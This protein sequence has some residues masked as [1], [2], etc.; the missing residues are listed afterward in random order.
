[1]PGSRAGIDTDD[2]SSPAR[3]RV[4]AT[5]R[6]LRP[7]RLYAVAAL[8][9]ALAAV[10]LIWPTQHVEAPI[11]RPQGTAPVGLWTLL[12]LTA[13]S[14]IAIGLRSDMADLESTAARPLWR[15]DLVYLAVAVPGTAGLLAGA[16]Y[17]AGAVDLALGVARNVVGLTG[18]ALISGWLLTPALSWVLPMIVVLPML[19]F[20]FDQHHRPAWWAVPLQ[21]ANITTAIIAVVM[22]G[23]GVA[24]WCWRPWRVRFRRRAG[25][26][27][28]PTAPS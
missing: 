10:A 28:C 4:Q 2:T 21:D 14:A 1:V 7:R 16:Y 18:L 20:G 17:I 25:G 23:A 19:Y 26:R 8:P 5:I 3:R 13:A 9:F 11:I 27:G 24:V 6:W 22:F 15:L 12:A